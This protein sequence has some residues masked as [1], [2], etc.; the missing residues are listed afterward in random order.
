MNLNVDKVCNFDCVYCQ[1]D[2]TELGQKEFVEIPRLVEEMEAMLE[3][4]VSGRIYEEPQL[5]AT[6]TSLRRLNDI[7]LSGDG[8]PTSYRNF[9]QIAQSFAAV[10]R[11]GPADLKLVLITNASM[12][13]RPRVRRGLEILDANQGE[14]WAKLDVGTEAYYR[15]IVR[16]PIPFSRILDNLREAARVRPIV[17]QSLFCGSRGNRRRRRSR[18]PIATGST[19]SSVT[20]A[21]SSWCRCTRWPVRPPS[22]ASRRC[23]TPRL[24]PWPSASAAARGWK[25]RRSTG[26]VPLR[27]RKLLIGVGRPH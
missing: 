26:A 17:I 6:P 5:A 9:D 2:R 16:S 7:A 14:I 25:W 15:R 27:G 21:G 10:R 22:A 11:R 18:T 12:F 23:P 4:V 13:H 1:V 24:T 19:R 20:A 8:E 3:L